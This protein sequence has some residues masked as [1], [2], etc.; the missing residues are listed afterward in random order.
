MSLPP[1][2][3]EIGKCYLTQAGRTRHVISTEGGKVTYRAG[4]QGTHW[5][6]WPQ[7]QG[8]MQVTFA[9]QAMGVVPCTCS[10]DFRLVR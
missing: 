4:R 8:M 10:L 2:G 9:L 3:I 1:E 7:R 5:K 6:Q